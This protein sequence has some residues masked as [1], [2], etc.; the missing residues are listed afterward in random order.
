MIRKVQT[1]LSGIVFLAVCFAGSVVDSNWQIAIAGMFV[2]L[3][4]FVG[5]AILENA[6]DYLPERR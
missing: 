4:A 5:I 1:W 3:V 6:S 2:A